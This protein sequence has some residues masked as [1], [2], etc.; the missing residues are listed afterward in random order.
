MII[1]SLALAAAGAFTGASLYVNY[2]EQPARLALSDEALIKEWEPSDHR[3]FIVLAGLAALA[4]LFGFI[5]YRELNDLRWAL[6]ALVM[7]ASWPYTYLA[8]VPLNNRI[9]GLIGADAAHDAR[10]VIDLWGKLEI[11][12]TAIGVAG[13]LIFVWAAG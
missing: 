6:G 1:G 4:A 11:G 12:L 7:L 13:L 2:V 10:K 9:L 3:G 5:A 8:I